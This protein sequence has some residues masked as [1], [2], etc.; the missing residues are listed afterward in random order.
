[1]P[2]A[3]QK[4]SAPQKEDIAQIAAQWA[5]IEHY[6]SAESKETYKTSAGKLGLL[7]ALLTAKVFKKEQTYELQ[8]MGIIFGDLFVQEMGMEWIIVEDEYGRD[9]ALR[10][11]RT[12]TI[13][14]PLTMISKRVER[15]E[16]VDVFE[17]F[18]GVAAKI[19][20][21]KKQSG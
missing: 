6:L 10:I 4:I 18:N 20:E 16:E 17:L 2:Q 13:I 3:E 14:Y 7:R 9:P 21:L 8:C 11:P 5:V 1:M 12:E 19:D 15:G